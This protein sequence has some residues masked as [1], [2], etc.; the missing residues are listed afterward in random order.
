MQDRHIVAVDADQLILR[1]YRRNIDFNSVVGEW[2][3]EISQSLVFFCGL[4][5]SSQISDLEAAGADDDDYPFIGVAMST[6][7]GLLFHYD[8]GYDE[9]PEIRRLLTALEVRPY[10]A[11][12]ALAE[13]VLG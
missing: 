9:T 1:E 2:F 5:E 11:T 13:S 8:R 7:S 3:K 6:D 12:Q 10:R 4:L